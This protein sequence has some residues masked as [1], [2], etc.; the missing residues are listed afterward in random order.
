[1]PASADDRIAIQLSSPSGLRA[2]FNANGSL[3]RL[4]CGAIALAL[5]VGNEIEGG[6]TNL[7]LRRH[8]DDITWTPLLGPS[9]PTHFVVDSHG[10]ALL[11]G[12]TWGD[13]GYVIEFRLA[14]AAK[15]WFWRVRLRNLGASRQTLDLT[16]AQDLA[17]APYGAVR[18]N[19]YYVSQYL[20]HTALSHPT[21]GIVIASRQNLAVDGRQPWSLIGS[22]GQGAAYA[23]DALQF[24]GLNR[25]RG[26]AP[27]GL[28][29][30]L[31]SSRLQHEHSMAVLRDHLIH[32]EPGATSASGFFGLYLEDHPDATS[33][34]DLAQL[35]QLLT[36]PEAKAAPATGAPS[37][38]AQSATPRTLFSTAPPLPVQDLDRE[39]LKM[40]FEGP[41]RHIEVDGSGE[42]LSFFYSADRHVVLRAK[43]LRV[44][45]PH[46][47]LL[48]SGR[49]STPDETSLTSTAWMGGV[50]HSMLTQGHVSINRMLSTVHS[51]L[52]LFRSHGQRIFV[53]VDDSWQLLE[54]PSA[55]E[56]SPAACSWIYRYDQGEIQVRSET[57]SDAHDMTLVVCVTGGLPRRFLI[58]HHLA[59]NGDDGSTPGPAL[60]RQEGSEIIVTP[61]AGSELAQRFPQGS[62]TI[63]PL[64]G[65]QLEKVG[66]DALLFHDGRSRQQPYLCLVT[67]PTAM[68]GLRIQGQLLESSTP[69]P[70]T[71]N[72]G[73]ELTPCLQMRSPEESPLRDGAARIAEM[74]PWFAQNAW[75]HYL[76][77][78]GLEQYS[79]GGWGTRDV[80]QGPVELLL[81]LDQVAPIRDLLLRVFRQQNPD[82]DW[83]Q[84]FMFF[85]RERNIRPNDSHG[86]IVFWPLLVLAQYL[87]A[88]GDLGI[89]Q[90]QARFFDSGGP[91]QGE[92]ATVWQQRAAGAGTDEETAHPRD[93]PGGLWPRRLER[94]AATCARGHASSA[95]QRL[96]G[97]LTVPDSENAGHCAGHQQPRH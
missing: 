30:D 65:T 81:A 36:Q 7:Y 51:Y 86:D 64:P 6:P 18:L 57:R 89:L 76:A 32:L 60:W 9:S 3:R 17:L 78:R 50:F 52:G 90:E 8:A 67:A 40:L 20:D 1:M 66:D 24:H 91:D 25:R 75:V 37:S 38:Q 39:A 73:S 56:M 10:T 45:R 16:Y 77:P 4:E 80:C 35:D 22:L 69:P 58:S 95:V 13:I 33:P 46:G 42:A 59:L 93:C 94:F 49:H 21:Q 82:G 88:S 62:F 23:T 12:G 48:R 72:A 15:A 27:V 79:G 26:Q 41:W 5:F 97:D 63:N 74:A 68:A 92:N 2:S 83:P 70:Q 55:F 11:G 47:H 29:G 96:D 71:L 85:E 54:V 44:L 61:A 28:M 43:E 53:E 19:E 84:W 14:A 31:P 34:A 87:I